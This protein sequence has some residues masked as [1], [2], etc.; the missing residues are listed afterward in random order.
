MTKIIYGYWASVTE[1]GA[2]AIREGEAAMAARANDQAFGAQ[3]RH[4]LIQI[5]LQA[6]DYERAL[7]HL[8]ILVKQN[9]YVTPAWLRID[10]SFDLIRNHPRFQ[11]I[12]NA[13][14]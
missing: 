3:M 1:R 11:A 4:N 9:Y 8:E 5:C 10:S 13:A 12:V 14:R 7:D 6:G 2:D